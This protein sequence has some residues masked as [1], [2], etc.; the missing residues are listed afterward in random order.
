MPLEIRI[1]LK[2]EEIDVYIL[3][4]LAASLISLDN[5]FIAWEE[6]EVPT[7]ELATARRHGVEEI[8]GQRAGAMA[9]T[10]DE[11]E[12]GIRK[13]TMADQ[14][15]SNGSG[16]SKDSQRRMDELHRLIMLHGYQL[17]EVL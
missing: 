3:F 9:S 7:S 6:K 2:M 11:P 16:D 4:S 12:K 17:E 5:S 14:P 10:L 13:I 8:D 15:G 1:C